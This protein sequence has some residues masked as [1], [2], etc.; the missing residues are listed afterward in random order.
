MQR[1]RKVGSEVADKDAHEQRHNQARFRAQSQG[2]RDAHFAELR[3]VGG[4]VS[5]GAHGVAGDANEENDSKSIN[6]LAHI[7]LHGLNADGEQSGNEHIAGNQ[8]TPAGQ[9]AL[10]GRTPAVH[11][12]INPHAHFENPTQRIQAD[13]FA[14]AQNEDK[15]ANQQ[16]DFILIITCLC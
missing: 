12:V 16:G 8:R 10:G 3:G 11:G 5:V 7:A 4:H 15:A 14:E 9:H 2:P 6:E 1:F 13:H